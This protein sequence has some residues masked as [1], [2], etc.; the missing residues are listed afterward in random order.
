VNQAQN[1]TQPNF[2]LAAEARKLFETRVQEMLTLLGEEINTH[3]SDLLNETRSAREMQSRRD[4]WVAFP[5]L[6]V[7]W[8]AQV[9][10]TWRNMAEASST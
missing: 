1:L 9:L 2:S 5:K 3:L 10:S 6:R 8:L 7:Q 4:V